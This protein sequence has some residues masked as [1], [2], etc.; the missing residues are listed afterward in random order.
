MG[1]VYDSPREVRCLSYLAL[2][3][4][5]DGDNDSRRASVWEVAGY[6]IEFP[7]SLSII[8]AFYTISTVDGTLTLQITINNICV[9]I[10]TIY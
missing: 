6:S 9:I 4:G 3:L 10:W 1:V 8:G 5:D 7:I 2:G